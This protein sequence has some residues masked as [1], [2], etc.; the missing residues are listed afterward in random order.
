M[1]TLYRAVGCLGALMMTVCTPRPEERA[2]VW[3]EDCRVDGV[4]GHCATVG[5]PSNPADESS[6][7]IALHVMV[8]PALTAAPKSD[9]VVFLAGGPG[10]APSDLI[11]YILSVLGPLRKHRDIVLIDQ[12]GTGRSG[13][14]KCDLLG[15]GSLQE[16]FRTEFPADRVKKCVDELKV[17]TKHYVTANLAH[18]TERVRVAL[19]AERFNLVGVSYGT[20]LA[21]TYAKL[22]PKSVRTMVLDAVAPPNLTLMLDALSDGQRALD[23][24]LRRCVETRPCAET[25]NGTR[26]RIEL[27]FL[28]TVERLE[29]DPAQ[30]VTIAHPRTGESVT[31]RVDRDAFTSGLF[32]LMYVPGL[33]RLL[34]H[35]LER[36][37]KG[38]LAPFVAQTL[39]LSDGNSEQIASGLLFSIACAEDIDFIDDATLKKRASKS[40]LGGLM[41][42]NMQKACAMWPHAKLPASV[43]DPIESD[44]PTLLLSGEMD[45][46]TPPKWGTD[47]ARHLTN[48]RHGIAPGL[49]HGVSQHGCAPALIRE[50]IETADPKALDITC[51]DE[52]KPEAAFVN[53][54]G[55]KP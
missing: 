32:S 1:R 25:F 19:G 4:A 23:L 5:V 43:R 54:L 8:I 37:A 53:A 16:H 11:P 9:P 20:R 29:K 18:D 21:L 31:V 55:P 33:V 7:Q 24:M 12:R 22:Y 34:P 41:V 15:D 38:D 35:T 40:F 6:K 26:G 51:L 17:D 47:A 27:Q 14:L 48:S 50:L 10:Q 39:M 30:L 36:A 46:V 2:K 49:A 13:R 52:L 44:V 45:P 3:L 42:T 28:E